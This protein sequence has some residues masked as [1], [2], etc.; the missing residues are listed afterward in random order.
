[1]VARCGLCLRSARS[2]QRSSVARK[3]ARARDRVK[4]AV[5]MAEGPF[6]SAADL[7]LS[8]PGAEPQSL[9][10][11]AARARAER[12]VLQLALAQAAPICRKRQSCSGQSAHALRLDGAAPDRPRCVRSF[13]GERKGDAPASMRRLWRCVAFAA[14]ISVLAC[15]AGYAK[16]T[17][18][19]IKEAE[20]Y[21]AKGNLK[22][23]EIE[24]RKRHP[25]IATGPSPSRAAR[26][27][28]SPAR[29]CRI[30]GARG[31]FGPRT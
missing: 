6:L 14:G 7:G 1:M 17:T 26:G 20:Q 24:L 19:S 16:E 29:R 21:V 12:E 23:A 10:I 18:A 15:H 8:A 13:A 3:W 4:R 5:V 30:G 11:R 28:V 9:G 27:S 22:A 2:D 31:A 25:R